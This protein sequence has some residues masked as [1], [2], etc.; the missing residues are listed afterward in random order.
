MRAID[1]GLKSKVVR[2]GSVKE[3]SEKFTKKEA[4]SSV[5]EKTSSYP[6]AGLI[7]RTQ[8]SRDTTPGNDLSVKSDVFI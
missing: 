5:T 2:R 8:T 4:S 6:K 3:M 7:Y 1:S